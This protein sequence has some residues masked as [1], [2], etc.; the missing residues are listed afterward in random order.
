VPYFT[1]PLPSTMNFPHLISSGVFICLT[2]MPK[3][4][5]NDSQN[6]ISGGG[7]TNDTSQLNLDS[8]HRKLELNGCR[9]ICKIMAFI[10]FFSS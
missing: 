5:N 1:L 2:V 6:V 4:T 8:A 7:R 10:I 9:L 3:E